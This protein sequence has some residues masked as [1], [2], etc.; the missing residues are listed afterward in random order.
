MTDR[1]HCRRRRRAGRAKPIVTPQVCGSPSAGVALLLALGVLARL[2]DPAVGTDARRRHPGSVDAGE[3]RRPK[4][5]AFRR[6]S[7]TSPTTA[8]S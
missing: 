7:S 6:R 2:R 4:A 8:P 5:A 1:Q 3:R